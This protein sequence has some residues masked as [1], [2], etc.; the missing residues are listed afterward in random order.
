MKKELFKFIKQIPKIRKKSNDFYPIDE[1]SFS[2]DLVDVQIGP[3]KL[4]KTQNQKIITGTQFKVH[5][6]LDLKPELLKRTWDEYL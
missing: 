3:R 5:N 4:S 1:N 2:Y 6:T